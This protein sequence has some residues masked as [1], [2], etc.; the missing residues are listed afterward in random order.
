MSAL[1][2]AARHF[3]NAYHERAELVAEQKG[4]RCAIAL[5]AV[6]GG[7]VTVR[8]EDGRIT[9]VVDH[10]EPADVLITSDLSTLTDVLE[11][12]RHPNEPYV[13]G[14]LTLRGPEADFL[15]L[16]YIATLLCP[17]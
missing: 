17:R 1:A 14:E 3:V 12:R 5:V 8:V 6:E 4:W 7:A 9:G 15:R 16:D 2:E 10:E 13:F 11:L